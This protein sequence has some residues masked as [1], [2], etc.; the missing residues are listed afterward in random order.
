MEEDKRYFRLGLFVVVTLTIL[1]VVLFV[2]GGRK[3]F[4]PTFTFET[5]FNE[6]VAGLELGA[7]VRF[8]GVPLGQVSEILTSS[9][10]YEKEIPMGKR[11][12]YIV[13]RAK[14]NLSAEEAEQMERDAVQMVTKG[15]R[16]QTQLAGITGQQYL[17]IDF[18]DPVKYPPLTF[19]WTP[20][21]TYVPSAPSL[22]GEIVANAQEFLASLNEANVKTLGQSLNALAVNLNKKVSEAPVAELFKNANATVERLD[23]ILAAAPIDHTL[24]KIDSAATLLDGLLAEPGL[25]QTVE[26]VAASSGRLRKLADDGDIDRMVMR[27]NATAE[28][29]GAL[30]GDNQYDL[31]V[32]VQD[33]RV[34][35]ANLRVFSETVKRYPA[36]VLVGGPPEKVK[37]PGNSR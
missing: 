10:T 26:N 37:L 3:L 14:V 33:L 19:Q 8:R 23:R 36:G 6:S 34:T 5:Y 9:A 17:A 31:G 1:A 20:K 25:K 22:T 15:L 32:I 4:Q 29:L 24:R 27:I 30:I 21:Y 28:R 11:R 13:V 7:P 2:L 18:L 16:A 12:E 35:A